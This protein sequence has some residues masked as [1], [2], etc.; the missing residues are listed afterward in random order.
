LNRLQSVIPVGAALF[1]VGE[2]L[3]IPD[4]WHRA[5]AGTDYEQEAIEEAIEEARQSA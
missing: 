1:I 2:I 3:S 4:A 5:M